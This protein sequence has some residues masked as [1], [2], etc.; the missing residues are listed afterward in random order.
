[1]VAVVLGSSFVTACAHMLMT[2]NETL[3]GASSL[4]FC[5]I[6][7]T[8]LISRNKEDNKIP[9]TFLLVAVMFFSKGN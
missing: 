4:A 7:M 8:A 6:L 2:K 9:L 3:Y 5:F 1:M